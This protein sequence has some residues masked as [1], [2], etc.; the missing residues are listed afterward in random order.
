MATQVFVSAGTPANE[1]QQS[2]RDAVVNAV[3]LAGFT[4]RLMDA[5]DWDHRNPLRGVRRAMDE[6][7]GVVVV[8]YARYEVQAGA[9]LRK[10]GERPLESVAFP[11]AWNQIEAAMAYE[12]QLPL[13]VIAEDR[14][15]REALLDS[16]NDV[17]PFWT[18][19]NT[20]VAK[21]DGF[22]GY[23][24]SWKLEV[25]E[26]AA[27]RNVNPSLKELTA[28]QVMS[29]LP[30]HDSLAVTATLLGA[31]IA[32]LSIGYRIGSGQWPFG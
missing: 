30:W 18:T 19:L 31:I 20:D 23:L 3:R 6:C 9:E 13:L 24:R 22:L 16:G 27:Q 21:S 4:P 10:E 8:A 5:K 25:E 2:F 17:K 11:T 32:A 26:R 28:W 1:S 12:K 29:A 15:R 7:R 14:L